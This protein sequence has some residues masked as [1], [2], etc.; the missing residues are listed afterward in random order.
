V[1]EDF[2]K[3]IFAKKYL[4]GKKYFICYPIKLIT[5]NL[6]THFNVLLKV[7]SLERIVKIDISK[8]WECLG[9]R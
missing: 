1:Y 7:E 4:I 6:R 5:Q 9:D 3:T 8:A 2:D